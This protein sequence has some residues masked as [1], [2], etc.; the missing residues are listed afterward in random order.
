M[1]AQVFWGRPWSIGELAMCRALHR[2]GLIS[3][4]S[5]RMAYNDGVFITGDGKAL[6]R[7]LTP[8]G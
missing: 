5:G 8:P 1:L 3:T 2:R 7:C 6:V 4:P